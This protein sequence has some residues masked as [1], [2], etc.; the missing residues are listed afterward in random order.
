MK[1]LMVILFVAISVNIYSQNYKTKNVILITLDGFRWQ[2]VFNG[3]DSTLLRAK[4]SHSEM[5]AVKKTFWSNNL[6]ERRKKLLPFIWGE[7]AT[8][9]QIIGNR[10]LGCFSN[11]TNKYWF[12]YPGYNEIFTGFADD[13]VNSNDKK[14]NKNMTVFEVANKSETYKNKV[15]AFASWDCFPYILNQQRSGIYVNAGNQPVTIGL[16][17]ATQLLNDITRQMAEFTD[18]VRYDIF[19]FHYAF[20]YLK[21]SRPSLMFIGFDETDDFGHMG[22]YDRYLMSANQSDKAIGELWQWLQS[23]P[24]YKDKTTL[25]ITCDHGRGASENDQWRSHGAKTIGSDQTWIAIIGPDTQP[26]GEIT[27][28]QFYTNQIAKSIA[29]LLNINYNNP[30]AG[31]PLSSAFSK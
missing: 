5:E 14:Y 8:K 13:S 23:Q 3:P 28:G 26:K 6:A 2:E 19:T 15:V 10:N 12:S 9:G 27:S 20:D 18:G 7:I 16:N 11:L 25:I 22:M 31:Q 29:L 24:E 17:C 30:K 1:K 21:N 4:D